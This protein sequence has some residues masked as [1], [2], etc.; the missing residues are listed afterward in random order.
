MK[1][2]VLVGSIFISIIAG[3]LIGI[4]IH[5]YNDSILEK[6]TLKEVE[7]A[8]R[9]IEKHENIIETGNIKVKT[10]PNTKIVYETLY[11]ECN[12]VQTR[13]EDIE[14]KDVNQDEDYFKNKYIDWEIKSFSDEKVE[15]YKQING[16]CDKHYIVK[17][18]GDYIAIYLLDSDGN[19]GLKEVTD[20]LITYLPEDDIELLKKGIKVN[21]DNELARIISDYE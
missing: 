10:S 17:S 5:F 1:K 18:Y 11:L 2:S 15:L 21:G 4:V 16:I 20:I 3:I 14:S 13:E 12:D 8:N 9:Y 19:E 7:N 6:A